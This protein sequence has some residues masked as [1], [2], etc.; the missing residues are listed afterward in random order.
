MS[1]DM[2]YGGEVT[3]EEMYIMHEVTGIEFVIEDGKVTGAIKQV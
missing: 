2:I 3:L 1:K